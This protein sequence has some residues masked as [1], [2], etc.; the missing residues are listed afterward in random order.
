[1]IKSLVYP[2]D[3]VLPRVR[4]KQVHQAAIAKIPAIATR[5]F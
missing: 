2:L 5:L 1:M 3:Q 4:L